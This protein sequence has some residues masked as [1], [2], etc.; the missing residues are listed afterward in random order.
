[1]PYSYSIK[2]PSIS[3][4]TAP[5]Y[6]HKYSWANCNR[7]GTTNLAYLSCVANQPF[8]GGSLHLQCYLHIMCCAAIKNTLFQQIYIL[9]CPDI[10][11]TFPHQ[12]Y[13]TLKGLPYMYPLVN[14]PTLHVTYSSILTQLHYQKCHPYRHTHCQGPYSHRRVHPMCAL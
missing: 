14:W 4:D 8:W 12:I 1:M 2:I 9:I 10:A 6:S 7:G 5:T 3:S 11:L 13:S